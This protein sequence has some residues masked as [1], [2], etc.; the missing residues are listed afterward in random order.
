MADTDTNVTVTSDEQ[1]KND[2]ATE[3]A[4]T[5]VATTEAPKSFTQAD[6]DRIVQS[7]LAE[8]E[9]TLT[10]K[11]QKDVE[12]QIAA[13]KEEAQRE[14]DKLVE[15]RMQARLAEQALATTRTEL[16]ASYEL[17]EEQ[18]ARLVGSSPDELKA[19]AEKIFGVLKQAPRP[20]PPVIKTGTESGGPENPLDVSK[21][22]P[23]EIRANRNALW[24]TAR[25]P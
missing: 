17:S 14:L 16:M 1:S 5:Q 18:A 19:D 13:A 11:F 6:V 20:K 9:R 10:G 23:A 4:I 7:R 22:T 24:K 12:A 15:D 8:K 3:G 2:A 21:M 25:I